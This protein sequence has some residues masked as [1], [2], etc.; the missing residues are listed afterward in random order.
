VLR[1]AGLVAC[2]ALATSRI[3]L[4]VH[5]LVG[6]GGTAIALGGS[7]AKVR[8]FWFAGGWIQYTSV[9]A[10]TAAQLAIAMGGIAV[11]L[12]CGSLVWF[13]VR[14][15]TLGRRIV[16]AV[17]AA[18]IVHA[19]WY[20]A[21]G[22]WHGYGD[23]QLLYRVLGSARY[24]VA[25]AAGVVT[26]TAAFA[27]ARLVIGALADTVPTA[28]IAGTVAALVLAGGLHAGL[29]AGE[30]HLRAD[31][32]YGRIMQPEKER[33][34]ERDLAR[35]A[36]YERS[37]G[38]EVSTADRETQ[39]TKLEREHR[40]FPFAWLLGAAALVAGI[41]GA[42]RARAGTTDVIAPRLLAFAAAWAAAAIG[43]VIA[44][45]LAL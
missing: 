13:L 10:T 25:L 44:I 2:V 31:P 38:R 36:E 35:W 3:G 15:D 21:T 18:L 22:A 5:E 16:R 11:E 40:T 27:G 1:L 26:C 19:S 29:A 23:G 17:G 34:V 14:G 20:L 7:I 37:M 45:D 6:H 32:T 12:A 33:L 8:L 30:V 24:P 41:A 42:V 28:R 4:V 43:V 9:P 39:Q